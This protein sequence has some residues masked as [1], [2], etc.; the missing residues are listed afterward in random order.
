MLH[1]RQ[2]AE[3]SFASL[4][5]R[6]ATKGG[7]TQAGLDQMG[8]CQALFGEVFAASAA[9]AKAMLEAN[10]AQLASKAQEEKKPES[11]EDEEKKEEETK[12]KESS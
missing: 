9:R 8:G 12:E 6:V 5:D 10:Q 2:N 1:Y 3:Q 7:V 4:R 11:L